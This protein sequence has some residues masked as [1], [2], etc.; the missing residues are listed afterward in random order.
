[1]GHGPR[2]GNELSLFARQM[3]SALP[4]GAI[5]HPQLIQNTGG[6]RVHAAAIWDAQPT[7]TKRSTQLIAQEHVP[8]EIQFLD[9]LRLLV[10]DFHAQ[11]TRA[12]WPSQAAAGENQLTRIRLLHAG[13]Q[14]N[15]NRFP[16]TALAR[17][18]HNLARMEH[19]VEI[20]DQRQTSEPQRQ[21]ARFKQ[22]F[23]NAP[24]LPAVA[25]SQAGPSTTSGYKS[26]PSAST[27][28]S[29]AAPGRYSTSA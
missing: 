8:G 21:S 10:N 26:L 18:T 14:C 29:P 4:Q 3:D 28:D 24:F 11:L 25:S 2:D 1:M 13:E 5:R 15:H 23:H 7:A 22:R 17:N 27:K 12:K 9:H 20:L 6:L 19:H 16:C